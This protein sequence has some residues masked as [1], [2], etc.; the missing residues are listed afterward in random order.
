[1]SEVEQ[2]LRSALAPVDPP[3]ALLDRLD[4]ELT[5]ITS[6]AAEQMADWEL[7]AMKD[8]RN[9]AKPVTAGVVA[10]VAGTALVLVRARQ[11]Q[12]SSQAGGLRALEAGAGEVAA[13]LRRRLRS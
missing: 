8:P 13:E 6:A 12:R 7:A 9:W 3:G 4:H 1:M 11:R 2:L 5:E 10:G